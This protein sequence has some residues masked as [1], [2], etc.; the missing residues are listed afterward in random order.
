MFDMTAYAAVSNPAERVP[1]VKMHR[2]EAEIEELRPFWIAGQRH[3][4]SDF[5]HFLLVCRVLPGVI[6]PVVMSVWGAGSCRA[7]LAGRLEHIRLQ[8]R[9]GYS[10]APAGS[11]PHAHLHS[12]GDHRKPR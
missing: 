10:E 6:F 5:E 1:S 11:L 9:L 3:P 4:N 8:P 7:L 12:G 2:S